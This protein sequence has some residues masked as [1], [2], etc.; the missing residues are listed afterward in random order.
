MGSIHWVISDAHV[1]DPTEILNSDPYL[2]LERI[3]L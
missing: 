3:I 2:Q 1:V